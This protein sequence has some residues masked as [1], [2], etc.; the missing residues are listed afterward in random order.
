MDD[1]DS[2]QKLLDEESEGNA[3][4]MIK[5]CIKSRLSTRIQPMI[6]EWQNKGTGVDSSFTLRHRVPCT[7]TLACYKTST[8]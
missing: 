7:V 8:V 4:E 1:E 6:S 5:I 2:V 3:N